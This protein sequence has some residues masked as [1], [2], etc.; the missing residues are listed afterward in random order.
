MSF[1]AADSFSESSHRGLLSWFLGLGY[2]KEFDHHYHYQL[3][4]THVRSYKLHFLL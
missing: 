3:T 2:M 4:R 1:K